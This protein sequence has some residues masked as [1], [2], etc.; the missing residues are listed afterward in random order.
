[1]KEQQRTWWQGCKRGE[2]G[3]ELRRRKGKN[4]EGGRHVK[5]RLCE[6]RGEVKMNEVKRWCSLGRKRKRERKG[7]MKERFK[8]R[9]ETLGRPERD[10]KS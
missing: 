5:G 9:G 10:M 1:M 3:R 4:E 6:E 2:R 8:K 7:K